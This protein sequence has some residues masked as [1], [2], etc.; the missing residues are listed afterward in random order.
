MCE[1][2]NILFWK[3]LESILLAYTF[4][5]YKH[6]AT[7]IPYHRTPLVPWLFYKMTDFGTP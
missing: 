4:G 2:L 3:A 6:G 7:C 5:E 1:V